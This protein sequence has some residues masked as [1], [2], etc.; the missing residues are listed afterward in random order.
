MGYNLS[1]DMD[2]LFVN[3]SDYRTPAENL[4][5][6]IDIYD[7]LN[8]KYDYWE[9]TRGDP[10]RPQV[11][12]GGR[13]R[14]PQRTALPAVSSVGG[15]SGVSR[16]RY[17][18][19]S[20]SPG[21]YTDLNDFL[22]GLDLEAPE[23]GE[24]PELDLPE[25]EMPE[26]DESRAEY[27]AE[28][29]AAHPLA[30]KRQALRSALGT[31]RLYDNP[32][33][34]MM[35]QRNILAGYGQ[36]LGNIMSAARREGLNQYTTAEYNPA[37]TG[38]RINFETDRAGAMEKWNQALQDR[39]QRF[40][41]ELSDYRTNRGV[42]LANKPRTFGTPG[43]SGSGPRRAIPRNDNVLRYTSAYNL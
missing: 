40:L 34:K 30:M 26:F 25:F 13:Y 31:A 17:G 6:V 5:P 38:A 3:P 2:D 32:N 1:N 14:Q 18:Y 37:I 12:V 42:Y 20:R 41:Q 15:R 36:G 7:N 8:R 33:M 11:T 27:Y 24:A 43:Y 10:S 19:T 39:N 29:A 16:G 23:L 21:Y 22:E 35:A 4:Q 28:R 9:N